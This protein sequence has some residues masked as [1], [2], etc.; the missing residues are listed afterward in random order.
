[1]HDTSLVIIARP[2]LIGRVKSRLAH[3]IGE[4][5][6]LAVYRQLLHRVASVQ[7]AWPGPVC[8]L[9]EHEDGWDDTGLAHLA[10]RPQP[11][12][13]LGRRIAA[14]LG[15][16]CNV[17]LQTVVIGTDCPALS[18]AHL[19]AVAAGLNATTSV[20]FGPA[21]DGGYWALG[22]TE[23]APLAL[24]TADDLPWSQATLFTE[25]TQRLQTHGV[26]WHCGPRLA[27]CD[28]VADLYA[29][30][31]AGFLHFPDP[32]MISSNNAHDAYVSGPP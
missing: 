22:V 8:L 31:A 3:S 13:G 11:S 20:S 18:L 25:S 28:E 4:P 26:T 15:W 23:S 24:L 32:H 2:P 17:A 1:M 27:D 19:T 7:A 30:V 12:G 6:A 16:G 9:A 21:E 5:A 29:A 10:R 14:G